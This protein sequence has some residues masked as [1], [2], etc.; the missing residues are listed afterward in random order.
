MNALIIGGSRGIGKATA[1][2]LTSLNWNVVAYGRQQFNVVALGNRHTYN[3]RHDAD[4]IG[5]YDAFIYCAGDIKLGGLDAFRFPLTFYNIITQW[6]WQILRDGCKI[7]VVSSVAVERPSTVNPHYAA[8]K[9]AMEHY[10]KTLADDFAVERRG[11]TIES[12]RFDLVMT[13]MLRQ[14]PESH[15]AGKEVMPVEV[16]AQRIV[17]LIDPGWMWVKE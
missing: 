13:D 9:C 16:A 6:G 10:A 5:G 12:I 15:Y 3:L 14:L 4:E 8:A 11:W 7:V 1:D 17:T 2:L